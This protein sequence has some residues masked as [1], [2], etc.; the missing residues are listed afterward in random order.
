M[1]SKSGYTLR[2]PAEKT[3]MLTITYSMSRYFILCNLKGLPHEIFGV[4]F[5]F[6]G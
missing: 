2:I 4:F 3:S 6:I 5:D 1:L